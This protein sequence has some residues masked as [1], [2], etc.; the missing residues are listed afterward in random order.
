MFRAVVELLKAGDHPVKGSALVRRS[1]TD[2]E[3]DCIDAPGDREIRSALLESLRAAHADD[4]DVALLEEL[5]LC[6]GGVRIDVT[7]VNGSLHGYEIKSDRDSL[8]RLTRQVALYSAVLDRAT[9]VV[10]ERHVREAIELVPPWWEV[11]LAK[12]T[13]AGLELTQLRVGQVNEDRDSR[14]LVELLWLEDALALLA[15]RNAVRGFRGKP[16]RIVWNRVCEVYGLDE[17]ADAVRERLKARPARRAARTAMI[18]RALPALH[19]AA[20]LAVRQET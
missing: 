9:L 13:P 3:T 6:R 12:V 17:I 18:G 16:R 10:G 19:A 15:A 4:D 11:V 1:D 7:V 2:D 5:G 14:A 20:E 8:R